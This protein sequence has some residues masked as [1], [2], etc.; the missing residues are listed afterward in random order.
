MRFISAAVAVAAVSAV[1]ATTVH[2]ASNGIVAVNYGT[3][4]GAQIAASSVVSTESTSGTFACSS[5]DASTVW[6]Y[7]HPQ[8]ADACPA[9]RSR[10]AS[11]S[12]VFAADA[13]AQF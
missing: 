8:P 9:I 1:S 3:C 13:C 12:G 10:C 11:Y 2:Y 4:S 6:C 7:G 5:T